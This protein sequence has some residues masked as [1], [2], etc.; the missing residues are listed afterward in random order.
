MNR[1]LQIFI[2]IF[3]SCILSGIF[4]FFISVI[5]GVDLKKNNTTVTKLEDLALELSSELEY[6]IDKRIMRL[7]EEPPRKPAKQYYCEYLSEQL[8]ELYYLVEKEK[9]I[10]GTYEIV[11]FDRKTSQILT[12]QKNNELSK[13]VN[14]LDTVSKELEKSL[15]SIYETKR[16]ILRQKIAYI[17]LYLVFCIILYFLLFHRHEVKQFIRN[18]RSGRDRRL[19]I[20]RRI[21]D[22]P[23]Y[24]GPERR[25]G[26]D[27]RG[28]PLERRSPE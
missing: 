7:A 5:A 24:Q 15:Q 12:L 20:E 25:N 11:G 4:V 23:N 22:N 14:E 9:I 28:S 6:G 16:T 19:G 17:V 2:S 27:R 10:S 18:R 26:P 21:F 3:F 8:F 13:L 1:R